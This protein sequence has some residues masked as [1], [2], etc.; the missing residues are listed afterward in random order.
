MEIW[1][2]I[3]G[4]E[5]YYQV[6][7]AGN[8]RSVER[9]VICKDGRV[10]KYKMKAIAPQKIKGYLRLPLTKFCKAKEFY[11][12]RL[13]AFAFISN[14]ENKPQVN[15]INGIK[16]DNRVENLEWCTN[17]ENGKHAIMLGLKPKINKGTIQP[18]K[19]YQLDLQGN[20]I[21]EF[22]SVNEAKRQTGISNGLI[23]ECAC[24]G[25]LNQA[26]GY[27]WSYEKK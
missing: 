11:I 24:G 19:V 18:K 6:S 15:H 23:S 1:K 4:F 25:R 20:L 3:K 26:G 17:G 22:A 8:V 13:V 21:N 12:H 14:P 16:T 2:D 9:Y 7:N 27:K 5:G 10:L